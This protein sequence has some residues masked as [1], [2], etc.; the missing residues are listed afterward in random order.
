MIKLAEAYIHFSIDITDV[1]L[2]DLRAFEDEIYSRYHHILKEFRGKR[3]LTVR[4][5]EGSLKIR[6]AVFGTIYVLITSYGS[7]RQGIDYLVSDAKKF[8]KMVA[9]DLVEHV[10]IPR[11]K[12][13]RIEKRLGI[14]GKIRRILVRIDRVSQRSSSYNHPD[15]AE[16]IKQIKSEVINILNAMPDEQDRQIFIEA[17]PQPIS[18]SLPSPLPR[19]IEEDRVV[20]EE[21][22]GQRR[23]ELDVEKNRERRLYLKD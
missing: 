7:F 22:F 10:N 6:L 18:S 16:E 17:L 5:E 14:P 21:P 4:V 9:S 8:D 20:I 19:P 13:Y 11:E 15:I 3:V 2:E 12:V 1:P 23:R